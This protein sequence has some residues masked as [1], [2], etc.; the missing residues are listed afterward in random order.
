MR[1]KALLP[2]VEECFQKAMERDGFRIVHWSMMG[3]HFHVIVEAACRS[4]LTA[5][6]KGLKVRLA[7]AL[8]RF[9]DRK[10]KVFA[11]RCFEEVLRC[12][13]QVKRCVRYVLENA[14]RHAG[15]RWVRPGDLDPFSSA[16]WFEGWRSLSITFLSR[17]RSRRPRT[18]APPITQ[19]LRNRP[20]FTVA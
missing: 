19:L 15:D 7:R 9:F 1:K 3:N 5:G 18:V 2:L 8:N 10:G 4:S 11:D 13:A 20:Q 12:A 6:V 14:K 17:L 16:V